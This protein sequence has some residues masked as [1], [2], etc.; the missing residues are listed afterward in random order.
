[1]S[2]STRFFHMVGYDIKK[3]SDSVRVNESTFT[4]WRPQSTRKRTPTCFR[5]TDIIPGNLELEEQTKSHELPE[6]KGNVGL[7]L[8]R[9]NI[10]PTFRVC[11]GSVL[12]A[13]SDIF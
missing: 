5:P 11:C 12:Y 8:G 10:K 13:V 2:G 6:P 3:W 4:R 7:I 1:M 9:P